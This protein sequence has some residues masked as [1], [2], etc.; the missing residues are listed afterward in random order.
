MKKFEHTLAWTIVGLCI[1]AF[2]PW[3]IFRPVSSY[4]ILNDTIRSFEATENYGEDCSIS[5]KDASSDMEKPSKEVLDA[6][7]IVNALSVNATSHI[8]KKDDRAYRLIRHTSPFGASEGKSEQ[9]AITLETIYDSGSEYARYDTA[10]PWIAFPK[11]MITDMGDY[12]QQIFRDQFYSSLNDIKKQSLQL[13]E[14]QEVVGGKKLYV[15]RG[16]QTDASLDAAR[17]LFQYPIGSYEIREQYG[18]V[19]IDPVLHSIRKTLLYALFDYSNKS[20]PSIKLHIPLYQECTSV[21][22]KDLE[23]YPPSNKIK[24]NV[25]ETRQYLLFKVLPKR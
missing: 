24:T 23:V 1:L 2:L 7:E 8:R 5:V 4:Q 18:E 17:K 14:V 22:E 6:L 9:Q 16:T 10:G 12:V 11:S 25:D 15:F 13:H 19:V 20:D 21:P 3:F